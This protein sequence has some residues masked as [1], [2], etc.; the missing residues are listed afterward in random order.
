MLDLASLLTITIIAFI[1][2]PLYFHFRHKMTLC[3]EREMP[4]SYFTR[5]RIMRF[6][7]L[8]LS[9]LISGFIMSAI[10]LYGI[11]SRSNFEVRSNIEYI[12]I[13][14]LVII[15]IC[16]SF[17]TGLYISGVFI[18]QYSMK[19]LKENPEYSRLKIAT[20]LLHG[21][22]SHL[23]IYSGGMALLLVLAIIEISNPLKDSDSVTILVYA[24][25]GVLFGLVYY[26]A[27]IKNL[28]WRFQFPG[29]A[30]L[31]VQG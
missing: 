30:F 16:M 2:A 3:V 7:I 24:I 27:Q 25:I 23:L 13:A 1:Y 19:T 28:S 31:F 18:E 12:Y 11:K 5:K 20:K 10:I 9:T 6:C 21:K 22:I 4:I 8:V 14:I 26:E 29:F 17:G 15:W